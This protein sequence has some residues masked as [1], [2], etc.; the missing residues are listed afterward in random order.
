[1]IRSQAGI[2]AIQAEARGAKRPG[3]FL[4]IGTFVKE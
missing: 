4:D 3:F 2:N 1:V